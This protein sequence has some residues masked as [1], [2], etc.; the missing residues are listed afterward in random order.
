MSFNRPERGTPY[1]DQETAYELLRS[2]ILLLDK[3]YENDINYKEVVTFNNKN[4]EDPLFSFAYDHGPLYQTRQEKLYKEIK[5]NKK[6]LP[7]FSKLYD[8]M[9]QLE[10]EKYKAGEEEKIYFNMV[11]KVYNVTCRAPDLSVLNPDYFHEKGFC[12]EADFH[13]FIKNV[14]H[15]ILFLC[16]L[17][18][19]REY[20]IVQYYLN[21]YCFDENGVNSIIKMLEA[22]K[23]KEEK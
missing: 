17:S 12:S 14:L 18:I 10:K 20:R 5:D 4:K 13:T 16:I 19:A 11:K 9:C 23:F 7:I 8:A 2:S 22:L 15:C 21:N 6:M 3:L 1:E